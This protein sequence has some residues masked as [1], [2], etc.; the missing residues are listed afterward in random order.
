MNGEL[1]PQAALDGMQKELEELYAR[2]P[3]MYAKPS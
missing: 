1:T 2:T 3:D